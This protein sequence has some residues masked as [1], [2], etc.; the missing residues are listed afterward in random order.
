M[1]IVN[2]YAAGFVVALPIA[3]LGFILNKHVVFKE[4]S[5]AY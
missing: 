2:V 4:S 3:L 5:E 1:W